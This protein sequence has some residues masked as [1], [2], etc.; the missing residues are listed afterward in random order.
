MIKVEDSILINRTAREVYSVITD[1]GNTTRWQP[2]VIE[3]RR[4]PEGPLKIGTRI[5]QKRKIGGKEVEST[6]EITELV[7]NLK[8]VLKSTPETTP[9]TT[10]SFTLEV[11]D[12]STSSTRVKMVSELDNGNSIS[13]RLAS[14]GVQNRLTTE[15]I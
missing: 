5:T 13:A 1:F 9:P 11:V 6:A 15:M 3:E 12:G 2:D 8:V 4:A 10:N 7:P 14:G